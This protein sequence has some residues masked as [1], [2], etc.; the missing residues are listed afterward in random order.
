MR[1][2]SEVNHATPRRAS[3]PHSPACTWRTLVNTLADRERGADLEHG[4]GSAGA[5]HEP[6][7]AAG[8]RARQ[9]DT[10]R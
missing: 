10:A 2:W 7:L 8:P 4:P 9:T 6:L 1:S 5:G 3:H